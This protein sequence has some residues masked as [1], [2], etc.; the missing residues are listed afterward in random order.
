LDYVLLKAVR[1]LV[2]GYEV[3][4]RPLWQWEHAILEGFRIFRELREHRN[5]IVTI[6]LNQRTINFEKVQ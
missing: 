2:T 3:A 5:G 4:Q 6:N 1:E